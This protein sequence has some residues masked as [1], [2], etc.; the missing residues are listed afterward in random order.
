MSK[1]LRNRT[2]YKTPSVGRM[3]LHKIGEDWVEDY[4]SAVRIGDDQGVLVWKNKDR[5]LP[6][7]DEWKEKDESESV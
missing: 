1:V 2:K 6:N 3:V 4:V 5:H 7:N